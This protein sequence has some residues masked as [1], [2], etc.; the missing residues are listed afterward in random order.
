[1]DEYTGVTDDMFQDMLEEL[2][3]E[4]SSEQILAIP[5]VY[6][7]LAE[8]LNNAV[9]SRLAYKHDIVSEEEGGSEWA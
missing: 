5:G 9:L 1:M 3:S 7:L 6:G 4:M 2:V 8:E